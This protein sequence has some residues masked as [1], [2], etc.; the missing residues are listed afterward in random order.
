MY[1]K[2]AKRCLT[3][4]YWGIASL[5]TTILPPV[6]AAPLSPADRN[7]IEQEQQRQL[8]QNQRQRDAL[9]QSTPVAPLPEPVNPSGSAGPCFPV[10][11]IEIEGATRLTP[12]AARQL[13]AAWRNTCLDITHL[14]QII[15]AISDW[16]IRRGYITSRA[17]LT[18]QDL[19]TGVLHVTVLEG[20]LQEI[21]LAGTSEH[22]LK[23]AFPGLRGKILNLRDLEQGMEQ[24]NRIRRIPVQIE[25]LPGD[26]Q[27]WSIV[28]LIAA[29]EL[30]F[31]ASVSFDNSGQKSTGVGQL[32][33]TVTANNLAGLADKWFIS[34]GRSSA[35][36]DF[37]DARN[38]AAGVS[39]PYGYGLL[40]YVYSW[41]DY[42]NNFDNHGYLWRSVGD[43]ETHR[44]TGSWVLFRNG[45][46]K[47]SVITTFTHRIN[48][49]YLDDVLLTSSSRKLSTLSLGIGHTQKILSGV[50][51]LNPT[52]TRGVPWLGAEKDTARPADAPKA[53][54]RKWSVNGSFQ[55]PLT[56]S[57]WWLTSVYFQWS[58]DRLYGSERLTI[59]GES[60]VRGF[61]EHY[62]SGD[63][64]GYWRNELNYALTTLPGLGQISVTAALDGGW[65]KHDA[66]DRYACGTLWGAAAGV[67]ASGRRLLAQFT[68]GTPL[69]AP[70]W[71]APDA[72]VLYYRMTIAF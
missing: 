19:S 13:T 2:P 66:M 27:G 70:H 3:L 68:A 44:L 12:H 4:I 15:N 1:R 26:S 51:T 50:A 57:L 7:S 46:L 10:A 32:S 55:T 6:F 35:F 40:D 58:P 11:H 48:H 25:I 24:L 31:S 39:L 67:S 14:T 64:G 36:S 43:S 62:L 63:N 9:E 33:G 72:L 53:A 60:S 18:E 37:S 59:G 71:L 47:T 8:E 61:K 65:L 20:R 54:F 29:P 49:N 56:D 41:S 52:F 17:F 28:N 45:Q 30:P 21:R 69:T 22:T 34:G 5:L 42:H 16:Y 23:M 38:F